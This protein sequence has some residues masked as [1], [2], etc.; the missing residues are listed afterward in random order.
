MN[1]VGILHSTIREVTVDSFLSGVQLH[2]TI[3]LFVFSATSN[4]ELL[5]L[6]RP[7]KTPNRKYCFQLIEIDKVTVASY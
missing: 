2:F 7:I 4:A 5:L 3:G 1:G 6:G